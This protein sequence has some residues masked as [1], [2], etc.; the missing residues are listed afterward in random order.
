MT[1]VGVWR[2]TSV[3]LVRPSACKDEIVVY[4]IARTN[5]ADSIALDGRKIVRGEE[6]EMGVL[7]CRFTPPNA[8]LT[9]VMPQGTWQFRVSKDSL[10]GELRLSNNTKV[11]DVR[12][13]RAP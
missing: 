1:P 11:R 9:C 2:G 4:R 12:T 7:A 13:S 8:L 6:E 10:V 3:C 5:T